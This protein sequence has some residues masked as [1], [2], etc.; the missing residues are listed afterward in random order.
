MH[1]PKHVNM[2][3]LMTKFVKTRNMYILNLPRQ[4]CKNAL[5]GKKNLVTIVKNGT[6]FALKLV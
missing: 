1:F 6:K 3:Q 5:L 4:I 2:P